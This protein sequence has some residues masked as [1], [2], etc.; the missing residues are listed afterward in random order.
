MSCRKQGAALVLDASKIAA[1]QLEGVAVAPARKFH[2]AEV[3]R[4]EGRAI[5][6]TRLRNSY[7]GGIEDPI[8]N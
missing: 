6:P 4:K 5:A 7:L 8:A 1:R 2:D 3:P